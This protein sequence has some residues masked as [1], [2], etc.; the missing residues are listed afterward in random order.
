VI[1]RAAY[2]PLVPWDDTTL[3]EE[4][5]EEEEEIGE[6]EEE[7]EEETQVRKHMRVMNLIADDFIQ[8]VHT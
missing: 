6:E 4:E 3:S 7:E 2:R 1:D 8:N 5:E